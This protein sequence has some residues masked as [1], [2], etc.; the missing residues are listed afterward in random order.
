[1]AEET[2]ETKKRGFFGRLMRV[3]FIAAIV[4]AAVAVFKRR[5]GAEL[6]E[7]EWQELPPPAGG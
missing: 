1:M 7:D 5:R 6:D 2:E 3:A 4:G